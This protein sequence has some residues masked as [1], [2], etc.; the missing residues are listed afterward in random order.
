[1][2]R[3]RGISRR[4]SSSAKAVTQLLRVEFYARLFLLV[5][6]TGMRIS[7]LQTSVRFQQGSLGNLSYLGLGW[8]DIE[9]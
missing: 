8:L 6:P 4:I 5:L 7:E 1:M 3:H 9:Q 2:K